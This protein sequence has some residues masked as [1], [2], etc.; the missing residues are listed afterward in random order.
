MNHTLA[1]W[2]LSVT[3][4]LQK[5]QTTKEGLTGN[6]A[7]LRLTRYGSNLLKPQKRSDVLTLL[8]AQ[9]K[10]QIILILFFAT[11]LSFF[12]HDPVDAFIILTIILVS[13]YR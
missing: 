11:V 2:N 4:M 5:L 9:F 10:S 7:R 3:E 12:L 13:C 6:E 1:F 8:L